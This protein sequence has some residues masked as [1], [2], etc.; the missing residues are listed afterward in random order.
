M[1]EQVFEISENATYTYIP[2]AIK[3]NE[4]ELHELYQ[5]LSAK[6]KI[7]FRA[8]NKECTMHRKQALFGPLSYCFSGKIFTPETIMN[9][10]VQ[11]CI[12]YANQ[13]YNC[14]F[15]TAL[16]N[17][18]QDG[19][20]YISP[21]RDNESE[22]DKGCPILTFSFG[23]TRTTIIT[24]MPRQELFK[25]KIILEH[26]SCGIMSGREFQERYKHSIP[27]DKSKGWRIS[28]TVRKF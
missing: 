14:Q 20:D 24:N 4:R 23:E 25:Q 10:L 19:T 18:Y 8:Y 15:N 3:S 16:C 9:S 11:Q 7:K 12:D 27:K 17:L 21:H 1:S 6:E 28:I 13:K 22:H 5:L 26:E 2:D